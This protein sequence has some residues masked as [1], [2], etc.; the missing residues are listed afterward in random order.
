M[1]ILAR[2]PEAVR[3]FQRALNEGK[4]RVRRIPIMLIGQ[5]RAGKTS[6]LKSLKGEAFDPQEESTRGIA[7]DPSL[8][9]V[10]NEIWKGGQPSGDDATEGLS[11]ERQLAKVTIK[12]LKEMQEEKENSGKS[13]ENGHIESSTPAN[14]EELPPRQKSTENCNGDIESSPPA[15][16]EELPPRHEAPGPEERQATG[17]PPV[18]HA[19]ATA[20]KDSGVFEEI[21]ALIGTLIHKAELDDD[22]D[23]YCTLWDFAGQSVFYSTHAL[24]LTHRAIYLLVNDLSKGPGQ[25]PDFLIKQ[26][27]FQ[28]RRDV[29]FVRT[30]LDFLHFWMTS[31]ASLISE[32]NTP[33]SASPSIRLPP[34]VFVCTHA[35]TPYGDV[36]ARDSAREVF[37]RLREKHYK[38]HLVG[39][40]F[41]VDNTQSGNGTEDM[42]I[43][44]LREKISAL[45]RQL[46]QFDEFIPVKW[47]R[48]E[49]ALT[50]A[51]LEGYNSLKLSETWRIA[52]DVC[53]ITDRSEFRAALNFLH[54]QRI[55]VHF[56]D[57]AELNDLVILKPQWLVDI[58]KE[59]ITVKPFEQEQSA[60]EDQ[61][62]ELEASGVLKRDLLE[63]VWRHLLNQRNTIEALVSI[64]EKFNLICRWPS[65]SSTEEFLVPHMLKSL[66]VSGKLKELLA[67]AAV[68]S[69]FIRFP[70]AHG[71]QTVFPHLMVCLINEWKKEQ[72]CFQRPKLYRNFVRILLNPSDGSSLV[73]FCHSAVIEVAVCA[74]SPA[75][76]S[77][78]QTCADVSKV[79]RRVLERMHVECRWLKSMSY[80]LCFRCPVCC[81]GALQLSSCGSHQV[82]DCEECA[83]FFSESQLQ[84]GQQPIGCEKSDVAIDTT[85][86][87]KTFSPWLK[88][89]P[90]CLSVLHRTPLV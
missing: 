17:G 86:P 56:D 38:S 52:V 19:R 64:M 45:C 82:P 18:T 79:L 51:S 73:L 46:P 62:K 87:V 4:T 20:D 90:Y 26:G 89:G 48:F 29:N 15:N 70:N 2:G 54:D 60:H 21:A 37:G 68:P 65:S 43:P 31:I 32:G 5:E 84:E 36:S 8:C 83:H 10:T 34:V 55:L 71:P 40:F 13:T 22:D 63:H 35:D 25:E 58:L 67:S 27:L 50:N 59:V 61:W 69:L 88:V 33:S 41:V 28:T 75:S 42:D 78:D 11:F 74:P 72:P 76:E 47:L 3:A 77:I 30:N 57:S 53:G 49:K 44:R 24:F 9:K 85:V 23:V 39:D 12:N 6:L 16:E 81:E 1:E 14:E 66:P 7:I 80:E